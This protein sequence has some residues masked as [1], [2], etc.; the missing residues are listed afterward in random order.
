MLKY[1]QSYRFVPAAPRYDYNPYPAPMCG[2]EPNYDAFFALGGDQRSR[3]NEDK[4]IYD[5]FFKGRNTNS[6]VG[7]S[8]V[9]GTYVEI[10]AFNGLHESNSHFFDKC[11]GWEG[12]LVEGNP[13]SYQKVISNREFAHK[14][15][16][17][18]SCGKDTTIQFSRYPMTNA[19]LKGHAKTYDMKPMV[20]VSCGPFSPVLT[21][22]FDGRTINFFSL[23]VEGAE[24]LVLRTIDFQKIHV[25]VF[26][27]EIQN[28]HCGAKCEVRDLVREKMKSEGY[29]RYEGLVRASDVYVYANSRFQIPESTA[30]P[31]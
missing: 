7:S 28:N 30:I 26:M 4:F 8:A 29:K 24:M 15:S 16:F 1:L 23:D 31:K 19:G 13:I 3:L 25:D 21:D 27:I 2:E 14:M 20:N 10:G 17:A 18:P 11:L 6:T 5:T 12:L 22:V 9:T